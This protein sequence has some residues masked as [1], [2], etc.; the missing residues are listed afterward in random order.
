MALNACL[1]VTRC[2]VGFLMVVAAG[3]GLACDAGRTS[4]GLDAGADMLVSEDGTE[5]AGSDGSSDA[6]P[7]GIQ[8]RLLVGGSVELIGSGDDACSQP[9]AAGSDRWCG[10]VTTELQNTPRNP[11]FVR[12]L[13]AI[14]MTKAIAGVDI[15]CDATDANCRLLSA[16]LDDV[17]AGD[18]FYG[19]TLIYR[20]D[21]P[22]GFAIGAW[23]WRPNWKAPRLLS[24]NDSCAASSDG[25]AAFCLENLRTAGGVSRLDLASWNIV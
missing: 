11:R 10:F 9:Q 13:W 21:I 24:D 2:C 22:S 14:N 25:G 6:G 4:A 8:K 23:V 16:Q 18:R 15:R 3:G 12:T 20:A 1:L 5:V 19:D 7:M 17:S